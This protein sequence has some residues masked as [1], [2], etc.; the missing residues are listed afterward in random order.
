MADALVWGSSAVAAAGSGVALA[1]VGYASLSHIA[2][3]L[4]LVPLLFLKRK[5]R[6][7]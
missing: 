4:A 7:S 2:A 3:F 6:E 1:E 5:R